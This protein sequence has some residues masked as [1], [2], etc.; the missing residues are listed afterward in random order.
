V[1][2]GE[3]R[4][5]PRGCWGTRIVSKLVLLTVKQ[6]PVHGKGT[7]CGLVDSWDIIRQGGVGWVVMSAA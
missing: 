4:V 1:L 7:E 3:V 2:G 5:R 6:H